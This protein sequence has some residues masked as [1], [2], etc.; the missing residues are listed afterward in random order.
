MEHEFLETS[1]NGYKFIA[2]L[3]C[4][5]QVKAIKRHGVERQTSK[6]S[7]YIISRT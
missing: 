1:T 4:N 6:F 5:S 3:L 2:K 7:R